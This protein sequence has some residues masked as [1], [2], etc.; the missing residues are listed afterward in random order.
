MVDRQ[1]L[2]DAVADAVTMVDRAGGVMSLV[3]GRGETGYPG[4][5]VTTAA[6][7]EWKDRSD[8]KPQPERPSAPAELPEPLPER[9]LFD[10]TG[11]ES[12]DEADLGVVSEAVS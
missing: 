1:D 8:A 10:S 4:E 11:E 6:V 3:V 5:M 9:G 12:A 7:V 2:F